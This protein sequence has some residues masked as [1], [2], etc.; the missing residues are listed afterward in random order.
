M[1]GRFPFFIHRFE[2]YRAIHVVQSVLPLAA[3][4]F[5]FFIL[6]ARQRSHSIR[7][8]SSKETPQYR[9]YF[10]TVGS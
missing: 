1:Q 8:L 2:R 10:A 4:A 9:A 6:H 7:F 5:F 3:M